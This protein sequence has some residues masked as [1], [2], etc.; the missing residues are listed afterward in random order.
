M[1]PAWIA[2]GFGVDL[3]LQQDRG[4]PSRRM[5]LAAVMRRARAYGKPVL[6]FVVPEDKGENWKRGERFG[7]LLNHG[8]WDLFLDLALAELVC[9][10][11]SEV[12]AETKTNIDGEAFMLLIDQPPEEELMTR[13]N[14]KLEI[15]RVNPEFVDD[16][17][18]AASAGY[19]EYKKAC[20]R[21]V[22]NASLLLREELR[23]VGLSSS[24]GLRK[25]VEQAQRILTD[26]ELR[27]VRE[28]LARD[29]HIEPEL[30]LKAS[31]LILAAAAIADDATEGERL[32]NL[33]RSI[34]R[35]NI[36]K[37]PVAGSRW[38]QSSGC[39]VSVEGD[40][41]SNWMVAC[42]MGTVT[43]LSERFLYFYSQ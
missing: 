25:W 23:S 21:S 28:Y 3:G 17:D 42:G 19:E 33:M 29:A 43:P 37:D 24:A 36:L 14:P 13:G 20:Q 6:V 40:P 15:R 9:A 7:A 8:S 30:F 35:E 34:A 10:K 41:G 2:R 18:R 12:E 16:L 27:H 31:A 5:D 26:K 38:A 32:R 22:I 4:Q 39:G 1:V 11:V